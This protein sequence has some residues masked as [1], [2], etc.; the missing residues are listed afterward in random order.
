MFRKSIKIIILRIE[1]DRVRDE[2]AALRR[3]KQIKTC[4]LAPDR[5][6]VESVRTA[7]GFGVGFSGVMAPGLRS[8][9]PAR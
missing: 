1:N 3:A 4:S 8:S 2:A 9:G 7:A 6:G 5:G